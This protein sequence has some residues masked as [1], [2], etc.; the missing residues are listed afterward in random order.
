MS[1]LSTPPPLSRGD[2]VAIL[3]PSGGHAAMF[4]HVLDLGLERLRTHFDLEPVVYP[5][6]EWDHET[7]AN[8]PEDRGAELERAFRDPE[9][10]GVIATIGGTDQVRVLPHLDPAV[11]RDNPTRFY[12]Y[13]DNT[14]FAMF[15]WNLG[16]VSFQGPMVLTELA[17]QGS[18]FE[19][20]ETYA[21]RAFFE[22]SIGEI[23]EPTKFTDDDLDWADPDNLERTREIEEHPGHTWA[24]GDHQI[25]GPTVGGNLSGLA[26]LAM[27]DRALPSTEAFEG[28]I[29]AFETAEIVPPTWYVGFVLQSLGERGILS[30]IDGVLVGRAKARSLMVDKSPEERVTYREEQRSK[31]EQI[32][33]RYNPDAP[34]VFDL[35]FGHTNPTV[36]LPIGAEVTIDPA[37]DRIIA[38]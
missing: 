35:A 1:E 14:S 13:S 33:N 18:M 27:A 8:R 6:T 30:A 2:T 7:L 31:I 29:L 37:N 22:D 26:Q 38:H 19:Y 4:P 10:R 24:G 12:G 23:T 21:K 32:I 9:I 3:A 36:P 28:C 17:M 25:R 34:I 20:T 11:F 15:L 5:S 16:I